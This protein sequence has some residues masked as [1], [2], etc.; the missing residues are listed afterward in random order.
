MKLPFGISDGSA[1]NRPYRAVHWVQIVAPGLA[2]AAVVAAVARLSA[3]WVPLGLSEILLAVWLG[4]M[5]ATVGW[6]PTSTA[7]GLRFAQQRLLR[8]GIIFLGARLSL[9]DVAAIG[10]GAL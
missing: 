6:L 1:A 8:L 3:Q 7:A 9:V 5:I 2:A 10:L 4:L